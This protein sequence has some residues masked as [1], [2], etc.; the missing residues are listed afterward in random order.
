[1]DVRAIAVQS[2]IVGAISAGVL[3]GSPDVQCPQLTDHSGHTKYIALNVMVAV[4]IFDTVVKPSKL[5]YNNNNNKLR[6][7]YVCS[8]SLKII[9]TA[10]AQNGTIIPESYLLP[11][12]PVLISE[13]C[14]LQL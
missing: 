3:L 9:V 14:R 8:A 4:K 7:N 12:T 6:Y 11:G 1:M 5:R 10:S 13:R 2:A